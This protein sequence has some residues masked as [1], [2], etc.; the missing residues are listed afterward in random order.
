MTAAIRARVRVRKASSSGEC[1]E[2]MGGKKKENFDGI[3]ANEERRSI[4]VLQF[5][6]W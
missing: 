4:M 3:T 5:T 6:R 1:E 2:G